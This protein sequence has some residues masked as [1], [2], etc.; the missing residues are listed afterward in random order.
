[1]LIRTITVDNGEINVYKD[2]DGFHAEKWDEKQ[3]LIVGQSPDCDSEEQALSYFW[4]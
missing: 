2:E 1:M 4:E 3:Q